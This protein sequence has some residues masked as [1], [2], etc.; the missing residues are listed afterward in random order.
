[1]YPPTS[2]CFNSSQFH[3]LALRTRSIPRFQLGQFRLRFHPFCK[4]IFFPVNCGI[5]LAYKSQSGCDYF[6]THIFVTCSHH[7][8]PRFWSGGFLLNGST[9]PSIY[10]LSS[11]APRFFCPDTGMFSYYPIVRIRTVYAVNILLASSRM[12]IAALWSL[13][14]SFPHSQW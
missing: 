12:L 9:E 6:P 1:M 14:I 7:L 10:K 4:L 13:S 11:R 8:N 5:H 3:L 2:N